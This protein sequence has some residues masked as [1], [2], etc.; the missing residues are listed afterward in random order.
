MTLTGNEVHTKGS[1]PFAQARFCGA[2]GI[3]NVEI[4]DEPDYQAA[5]EALADV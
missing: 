2:E 1:L 5:L 4:T 3:G